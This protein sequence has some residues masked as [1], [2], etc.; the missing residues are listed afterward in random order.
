MVS[1]HRLPQTTEGQINVGDTLTISF[2]PNRPD[3]FSV[4]FQPEDMFEWIEETDQLVVL[5][6]GDGNGGVTP[7]LTISIP[8]R[9]GI[10]NLSKTSSNT[11]E[12]PVVNSKNTEKIDEDMPNYQ[13]IITGKNY[14][15]K[16]YIGSPSQESSGQINIGDTL[17]ISFEPERPDSYSLSFSPTDA[18]KWIAETDQLVVLKDT[19]G[20]MF[21][22]TVSTHGS[23]FASNI[24]T[25]RTTRNGGLQIIEDTDDI[26]VS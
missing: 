23:I 7:T 25:I 8:F 14:H 10:T 19:N 24:F 2:S 5:K 21:K 20:A 16:F 17:T 26:H 12:L 1:G 3:T 6:A 4:S 22:I 15:G 9:I 11:I 13:I 18:F